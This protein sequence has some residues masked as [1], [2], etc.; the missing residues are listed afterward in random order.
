VQAAEGGAF[1]AVLINI[2]I[3]SPVGTDDL[4]LMQLMRLMPNQVWCADITYIPMAKRFVN[5]VR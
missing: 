4:R 3:A 5:L 1:N 2:L